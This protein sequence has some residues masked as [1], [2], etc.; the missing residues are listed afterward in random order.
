M[1]FLME[2]VATVTQ[3][4]SLSIQILRD[5]VVVYSIIVY[6]TGLTSKVVAS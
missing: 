4:P 5:G 1:L 2:N 3:V 6:G